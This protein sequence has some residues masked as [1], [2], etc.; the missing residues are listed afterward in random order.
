MEN[1]LSL[2]ESQEQEWQ[3]KQNDIEQ[4]KLGNLD[5]IRFQLQKN[6]DEIMESIKKKYEEKIKILENNLDVLSV[7]FEQSQNTILELNEQVRQWKIKYTK[8]Q[9]N[10]K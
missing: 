10:Q 8:I 9:V 6:N 4:L 5:E 1:K 3:K 7:E 2:Y